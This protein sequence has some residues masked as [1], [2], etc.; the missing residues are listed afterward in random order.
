M[1]RPGICAS[2]VDGTETIV[3]GR[4]LRVAESTTLKS[5]LEELVGDSSAHNRFSSV[6]TLILPHAII[7]LPFTLQLLSQA[8]VKMALWR[9]ILVCTWTLVAVLS[10]SF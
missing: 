1:R 6:H 2:V 4:A 9:T 7:S 5:I 10:T 3:N 8:S